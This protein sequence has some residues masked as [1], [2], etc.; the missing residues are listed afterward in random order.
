MIENIDP[1]V[2][3][4]AIA[5]FA[6]GVGYG[7]S[8]WI[9]EILIRGLRAVFGAGSSPAQTMRRLSEVRGAR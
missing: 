3:S 1:A 5:G 7:L 6:F 2:R 9:I 8:F 4:A